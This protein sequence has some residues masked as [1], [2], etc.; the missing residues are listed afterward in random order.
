MTKIILPCLFIAL[1]ACSGEAPLALLEKV[2]QGADKVTESTITAAAKSIDRYCLSVPEKKRT[3]IR[4]RVNQ[5]TSQGDI[6]IT[7][8]NTEIQ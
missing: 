4:N 7:C 1:T 8:N 3:K 5:R 6:Q 2:R